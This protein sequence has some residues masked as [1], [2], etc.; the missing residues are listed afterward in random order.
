MFWIYECESVCVYFVYVCV[1]ACVSPV[2]LEDWTDEVEENHSF[3]L[4]LTFIFISTQHI[5]IYSTNRYRVLYGKDCCEVNTLI[6]ELV[7]VFKY[8][9]MRLNNSSNLLKK[10]LIQ[11]LHGRYSNNISSSHIMNFN[12]W[13]LMLT[14]DYFKLYFHGENDI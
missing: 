12:S 1:H 11:K 2:G 6:R 7:F 14:I 3:P 13:T 4:H 5:L 9:I 8:Y 10:N